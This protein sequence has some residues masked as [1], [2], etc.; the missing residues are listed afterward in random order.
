M[1]C[2]AKIGIV[3]YDWMGRRVHLV[4]KEG[5]KCL[6]EL[7]LTPESDIKQI[8]RD[9]LANAVNY[10]PGWFDSRLRDAIIDKDELILY[11]TCIIPYEP[12]SLNKGYSYV[13]LDEICTP[14]ESELRNI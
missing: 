9:N 5:S 12:A 13:N 7:E 2:F 10:S 8:V 4:C 14:I 1:K 11:Y 6:L 3:S